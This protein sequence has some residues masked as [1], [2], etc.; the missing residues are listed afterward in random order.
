V[1]ICKKHLCKNLRVREDAVSVCGQS[2]KMSLR[3]H[4]KHMHG[5]SERGGTGDSDAYLNLLG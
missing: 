1:A 3:Y 5:G 2:I 4:F